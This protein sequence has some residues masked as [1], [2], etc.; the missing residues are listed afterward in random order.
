MT[1]VVA[2]PGAPRL[3][4]RSPAPQ[5]G[6]GVLAR[7]WRPPGGLSRPIGRRG[8]A[9]GWSEGGWAPVGAAGGS[10]WAGG[11]GRAGSQR[12]GRGEGARE[13][14]G[15]WGVRQLAV[16]PG[17]RS[18]RNAQRHAGG[19]GFRRGF[20]WA[21]PQAWRG[22]AG[23][24]DRAGM[25]I[26]IHSRAGGGSPRRPP[27][28]THN[29]LSTLKYIS[30]VDPS[31]GPFGHAPWG[32][33]PLARGVLGAPPGGDAPEHARKSNHV[34]L[35]ISKRPSPQKVTQ[36]S[37]WATHLVWCFDRARTTPIQKMSP[38]AISGTVNCCTVF[39]HPNGVGEFV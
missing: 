30:G 6:P 37:N 14:R 2:S 28:S 4:S 7:G 11:S 8:D 16:R 34:T 31:A 18:C 27:T 35:S 38:P 25:V 13:V 29:R 19:R 32:V 15:A 3:H 5:A 10:W 26:Y 39:A 1:P 23:D 21:V 20:Q 9:A 24:L 17:G 22:W 36:D 33:S 12:D